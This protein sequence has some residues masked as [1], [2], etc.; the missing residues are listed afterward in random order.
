MPYQWLTQSLNIS[1][2]VV[3]GETLHQRHNVL[4]LPT[5]TSF[6]QALPTGEPFRVSVHAWEN[7]E[8]SRYTQGVAKDPDLVLFEA[9]VLVD[10]RLIG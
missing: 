4:L 3:G 2:V 1:S 6:I 7:P 5:V 8:P 9:R 10:G